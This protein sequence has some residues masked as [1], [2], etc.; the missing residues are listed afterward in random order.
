MKKIFV[1]LILA[2]FLLPATSALADSANAEN[3]TTASA[4]LTYAP[5]S[6]YEAQQD[7]RF[8]MNVPYGVH[9]INPSQAPLPPKG[10][11]VVLDPALE[12]TFNRINWGRPSRKF[13]KSWEDPI[14]FA[15]YSQ[16]IP[17]VKFLKTIPANRFEMGEYKLRG[18]DIVGDGQPIFLALQRLKYETGTK[19]FYVLKNYTGKA[20]NAGVSLSGDAGSGCPFNYNWKLQGS[21]GSGVWIN[22]SPSAGHGTIQVWMCNGTSDIIDKVE[23]QRPGIN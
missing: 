23:E 7:K 17:G 21:S 20:K 4:N 22:I 1:C 6:Y 15:R 13:F 14:V 11:S 5:S 18:A 2:V 9:L 10:W 8:H 16:P 19:W 12:N 3:T